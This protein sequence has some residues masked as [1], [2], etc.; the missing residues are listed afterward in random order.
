MKIAVIL[1]KTNT[2]ASG[3]HPLMLR[4][5]QNK[6]RK[7][8][9]L[10]ISC[11]PLLW[12]FNKNA[13]RKH[14]PNKGYLEAIIA[15]KLAAY[16]AKLLE[17]KAD[18]VPLSPQGLI[19]AMEKTKHVQEVFAFLE[20]LIERF[21]QS[22]R[23]GNANLYK[24]TRRALKLFSP[25]TP[26]LFTDIDPKFLSQY[27][28]F[29]RSRN[30]AENSVFTYFKTLRALFNKAIH[31]GLVKEE[32]YPFKR[33]NVSKFNTTTQKRA[34]TKAEIKQIASLPIDPTST[35]YEARH[36]FLFSYYGQGINFR[37]IAFLCWKDL[38][39]DR[40]F[41]QRAK[42]KKQLQFKLLPP[43]EAI[44]EEFR[45][46]TGDAPDNYMFPILNRA[47]HLTP[48]QI[49]DRLEKV[50][51]RMNKGLKE[52]AQLAGISTHLT[53]YVA[54]HTYATVLKRSGVAIP[55]IS[56]AMGHATPV[57]TQTYLKSFEDEVIDEA[58]TFLL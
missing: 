50:L 21:E 56:E 27:E 55:V 28:V 34:I 26:L 47:V 18:N 58:N 10:G 42:T 25:N 8:V 51:K 41:Y 53:M 30:L 35:L 57:I 32:L 49:N 4:V 54:R 36:Y 19:K 39:E 44:I 2:L 33:F 37:D 22:G 46:L 38:I 15:H 1:Y 31:E 24:D 40:I 52:I 12:D 5:S 16:H 29:L 6:V 48:T 23:I 45:P 20:E 7:Y 3:E 17:M 14:H 43:A 9:A 11:S 13:P